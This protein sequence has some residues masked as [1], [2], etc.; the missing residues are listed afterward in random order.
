MNPSPPDQRSLPLVV[1]I[2]E[3][4]EPIA[5]ALSFIVEDA[6]Y[7]S[8]VAPQGQTALELA[9]KVRPALI[10]T[11]LMMPRMTGREL[12][13][14]LRADGS[15]LRD[16]PIILMTAAGDSLTAG[17]GADA[18]LAKPFDVTTVEELLLR[19]LGRPTSPADMLQ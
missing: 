14:A 9:A 3:D 6:G 2:V 10:I 1:L 17:S 4:E 15:A 7:L 16:I 11:D 19:F 18:V 12:I 13:A 5:V 8:L